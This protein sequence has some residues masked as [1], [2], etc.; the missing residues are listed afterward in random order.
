[1]NRIYDT[2]IIGAGVTGLAAAMYAGRLNLKTIVLGTTSDTE[3][4]IGGIITLAKPIENYPG[5]KSITGQELAKKIEEHARDYNI[6]IKEEKVV[7]VVKEVNY[8][9][10][11]TEKSNYN[12]NCKLH[13]LL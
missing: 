7:D 8:F 3:L 12:T 5:F 2:I 13:P 6:K 11:K 1:M 10:I 9:T 4:P